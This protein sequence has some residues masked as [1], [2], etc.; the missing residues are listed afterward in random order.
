MRLDRLE[1]G[2]EI[3]SIQIGKITFFSK[4]ERHV[5]D[6][7]KGLT[8]ALKSGVMLENL[9][10]TVKSR[11]RIH[12]R[13][14]YANGTPLVNANGRLRT[15][16]RDETNP[17]SGGSSSTDFFT[18]ADGYF[19]QYRDEPGFYTLSTEYSGL[20]GGAG[21]FLLKDGVA[22]ENLVITLDGQ[23]F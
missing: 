14:V 6:F 9:K 22:P 4:S 20:S 5:P 16:Q 3:L 18:D 15:R 13:I 2:M 21:P 23:P 8:F 17:N 11:L 1:P 7:M 10:I 19:T 12:G